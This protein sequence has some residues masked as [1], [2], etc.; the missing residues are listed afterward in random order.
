MKRVLLTEMSGT[1]KSSTIRVLAARGYRAVDA[2]ESGR[3][4]LVHVHGDSGV[5]LSEPGQD[6][7]WREDRIRELLSSEDAGVLFEV[8]RGTSPGRSG[9]G[10]WERRSGA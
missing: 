10:R 1:G 8:A 6:W 4:E 2:D 9:N 5:S 3:S 7:L